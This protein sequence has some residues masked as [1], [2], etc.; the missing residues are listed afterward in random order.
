MT[1]KE[2]MSK[3]CNCGKCS[4][5]GWCGDKKTGHPNFSRVS[6]PKVLYPIV[7]MCEEH[8]VDACYAPQRLT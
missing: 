3:K 8:T 6:C 7:L 2:A 5:G 4:I 1:Y